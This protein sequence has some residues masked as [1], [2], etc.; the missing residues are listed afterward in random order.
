MIQNTGFAFRL[1]NKTS[2]A[3]PKN[4]PFLDAPVTP[5]HE[6]AKQRP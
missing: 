5:T 1:S 2:Q 4:A 3:C 6:D